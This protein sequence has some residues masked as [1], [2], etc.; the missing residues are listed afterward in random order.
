MEV[1]EALLAALLADDDD[2]QVFEPEGSRLGQAF[3]GRRPGEG[4]NPNR[5]VSTMVQYITFI[6]RTVIMNDRVVFNAWNDTLRHAPL[7]AQ[8]QAGQDAILVFR[9]R[10]DTRY[11]EI[12]SPDYPLP[13]GLAQSTDFMNEFPLEFVHIKCLDITNE[14][15]FEIILRNRG[16]LTELKEGFPFNERHFIVS[17]NVL[18]YCTAFVNVD[19]RPA[20]SYW[21]LHNG[22]IQKTILGCSMMSFLSTLHVATKKSLS[23]FGSTSRRFIEMVNQGV[24]ENA[25][26]LYAMRRRIEDDAIILDQRDR[27]TIEPPEVIA[28]SFD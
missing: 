8:G 17:T 26:Q 27:A 23:Q 25:E 20:N 15:D 24:V 12:N 7:Q 13:H 21:S 1:D 22:N 4:M 19:Y 5:I 16:W 18:L 6:I 11:S 28:A 3:F 10:D 2:E 14:L 9:V